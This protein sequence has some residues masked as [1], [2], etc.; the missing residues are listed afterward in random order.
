M[1]QQNIQI[2]G[3]QLLLKFTFIFSRMAAS[4]LV[5]MPTIR[6]CRTRSLQ[7]GKS[8]AGINHSERLGLDLSFSLS[9][10]FF[11]THFLSG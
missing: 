1:H 2:R 11:L 6:L 7:I 4:E 9:L 3:G 8:L 5:L 10:F